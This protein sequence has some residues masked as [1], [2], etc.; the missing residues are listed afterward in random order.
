MGKHNRFWC[1]LALGA[2]IL[3]F[4]GCSNTPP[5]RPF[6]QDTVT[7]IRLQQD[8]HARNPHS[9]PANVT[10]E[11][12]S[13]ILSGVRVISRQ[14]I[15][16]SLGVGKS[17]QTPAF[18]AIEIYTLA[19]KL[20]AALTQ[21]QPNELVTFYSR[22]SD[23]NIGLGIT[24]GGLFVQD[25]QLYFV[26][27]NNRT[28][29]TAGMG[30][31]HIDYAIDPVDTPLLPISRLDFRTG[32]TPGTA[33]IRDEDRIAWPYIDQGRLLVIDLIQLARDTKQKSERE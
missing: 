9:H 29:P 32:F 8:E 6:Y 12:M 18:S 21:A 28:L 24:S 33:L 13:Q 31:Q 10:P 2:V 25:Q 27:A 15:F 30:R 16:R 7:S 19:P 14:G 3:A 11:M 4:W 1:P 5:P 23:E 17:E 20:S 26:L 22:I